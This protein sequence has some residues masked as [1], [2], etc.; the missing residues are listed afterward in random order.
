MITANGYSKD[1]SIKPDGIVIT[2]PPSMWYHPWPVVQR[3]FESTMKEGVWPHRV[4]N[5]PKHEIHY[6]Y[7]IIDGKVVYR[8]NY[9]E[10]VLRSREYEL[11][12]G[13]TFLANYPHI[14]LTGPLVKAPREILLPGF[15][16][17]R[18]CTELF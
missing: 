10:F 16:G 11:A 5:P 4:K 18:Y 9:L 8:C 17:F 1:P 6:V 2:W 12:T 3:A 15:Q 7:I 13:G 14:L